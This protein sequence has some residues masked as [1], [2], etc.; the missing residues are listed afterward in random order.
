[1]YDDYEIYEQSAQSSMTG[2]TVIGMYSLIMALAYFGLM[3][4][5]M[6]KIAHRTGQS[7]TAWWAFIPILNTLLLINMAGKP[8]NWVFLLL[9]P[10]VNVFAF[11]ALW[12]NVARNCGQSG[13]WGFFCMFPLVNILPLFV[14]AVSTR[15]YTYPD[16]S[17]ETPPPR[18]REPHQVG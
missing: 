6:Y 12:I 11:F 9:I 4:F 3:A 15:P 14:L 7:D 1:M 8:I 13:V 10:F 2:E 16:F 5:L 17:D 18:P